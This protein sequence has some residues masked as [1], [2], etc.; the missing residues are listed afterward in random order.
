M[1]DDID[2]IKALDLSENRQ[3][4]ASISDKGH[5]VYY[6]VEAARNVGLQVVTLS[7]AIYKITRNYAQELYKKHN[8]V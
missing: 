8:L 1:S 4:N 7:K 2:Y 6:T 3:I 5:E